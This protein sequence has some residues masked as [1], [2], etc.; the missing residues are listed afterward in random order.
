MA[1]AGCETVGSVF[2]KREP[3]PACPRVVAPPDASRLTRFNGSGRDLTDVLFEA[4][5]DRTLGTCTY[6]SDGVDIEI[7]V[8]IVASRGP[9]DQ[10]RKSDFSYFVSVAKSDGTI[11]GPPQHF[12]SSIPFPGNQ[13]KSFI[14]EELESEIRLA[15]SAD[16]PSYIVFV[17]FQLTQEELAFNRKHRP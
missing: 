12:D 9:A 17:G 6:G 10:S 11:V 2:K 7:K 4:E 8:K 14:V 15:Q 3:P 13:T 1:L 5:I 16:G